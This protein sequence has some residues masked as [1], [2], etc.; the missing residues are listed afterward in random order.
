MSDKAKRIWRLTVKSMP[1]GYFID[2]DRP[3]LRGFCEASAMMSK[4]AEEIQ[5]NG[6]VYN[7]HNGNP[8]ESPWVGIYNKS[9]AVANSAAVKLRISKSTQVTP[10][11]A[12]RAALDAREAVQTN[13]NDLISSLMQ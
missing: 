6:E 2:A 10:E 11:N 9:L 7:D 1:E 4:A 3:I 12:G 8:K 5:K 13:K